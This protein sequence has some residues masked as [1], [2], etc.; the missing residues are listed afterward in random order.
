MMSF[1]MMFSILMGC[2]AVS[3]RNHRQHHARGVVVVGVNRVLGRL[4]A[5][6]VVEGLA[7]VRVHVESR[8]V[9][10]RDVQANAVAALEDEGGGIHLDREIGGVPGFEEFLMV[11]RK[12]TRLN[13]SH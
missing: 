2:G 5:M 10:A 8:E 13:S 7:G 9:A 1:A 11:D 4:P 6:I 12:S 3:I